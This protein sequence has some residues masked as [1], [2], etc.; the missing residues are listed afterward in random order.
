MRRVIHASSNHAVG[1]HE[2]G[3]PLTTEVRTRPDSLYGVT[4]V[5]GEALGSFYADRYGMDVAAVRIG[6]CFERPPGVRGL[7]TW[8]SPGDS[9]RLMDALLRAPSF[10]FTVLYGISANTRARWDLAPALSLGYRPQDDAEVFA[11]EIF[12]EFGPLPADAPD[13]RFVGG[14]MASGSG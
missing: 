2:T 6:S 11:Q 10:G 14:R 13:S 9:V 3:A 8:L 4:K 1:F 7:G 12:A 5:F